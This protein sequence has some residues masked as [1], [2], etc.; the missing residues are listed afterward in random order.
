MLS[1]KA[2]RIVLERPVAWEYK[3]FGQSL[4][5]AIDQ[6][7]DIRREHKAGIVL[8]SSEH[9]SPEDFVTWLQVRMDETGRIVSAIG[10]LIDTNIQTA[11][12]EPGQ[13]GDPVEISFVARNLGLAYQELIEWSQ[14]V[15]RTHV[16]TD[17]EPIVKNMSTLHNQMIEELEQFGPKIL[18]Q[19]EGALYE[20]HQV[21]PKVLDLHFNIELLN[22]DDFYVELNILR[23]KLGV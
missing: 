15:K 22:L 10:Q 14:K 8:G 11:L 3:L 1:A 23:E 7:G 4:I 18:T 21:K 13:P 19:I 5:D 9:V 12:G 20:I 6:H 2:F 16:N 17:F